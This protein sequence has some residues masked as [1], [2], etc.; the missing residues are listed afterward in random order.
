MPALSLTASL[1]DAATAANQAGSG[2]RA[3]DAAGASSSTPFSQTLQQS[4]ANQQPQPQPQP[5]PAAATT[6]AATDPSSGDGKVR[7]H[8][9]GHKHADGSDDADD[10]QDA[11]TAATPADAAALAAAAAVQAQLQARQDAAVGL[12]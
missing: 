6:T 11:Q 3:N 2:S 5:K 12:S 10:G 9:G 4:V 7:G 1:L 8:H